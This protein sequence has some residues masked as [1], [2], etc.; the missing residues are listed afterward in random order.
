[1]LHN[2][3]VCASFDRARLAPP[4]AEKATI[5]IVRGRTRQ[6]WRHRGVQRFHRQGPNWPR[7]SRWRPWK[8]WTLRRRVVVQLRPVGSQDSSKIL[9]KFLFVFGR[10]WCALWCVLVQLKSACLSRLLGVQLS[11]MMGVH[12]GQH[13]STREQHEQENFC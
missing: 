13:G 4:R 2:K 9:T 6:A 11:Q 10:D 7:S 5:Q 12:Y 8:D 3:V 1:M